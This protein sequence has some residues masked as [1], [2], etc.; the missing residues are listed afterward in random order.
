MGITT[1]V[2]NGAVRICVDMCRAN[3]AITCERYPTPTIDH[4]IHTLNG[5]TVF[6]E[7]DLRSGCHQIVLAPQSRYITMFTTHK[8]FGD[9]AD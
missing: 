4:L 1:L 7:L 5:A 2:K 3:K 8:V 9:T 6:S